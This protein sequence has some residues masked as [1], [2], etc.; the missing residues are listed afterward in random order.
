MKIL[1]ITKYRWKSR[2]KKHETISKLMKTGGIQA[3]FSTIHLDVGK[4]TITDGRIDPQWYETN[5]TKHAQ[6]YDHV[7]FQF[8]ESD[9]KRWGLDSGLRGVNIKDLD[10]IGESWVCCDEHSVVK[11]KDGTERD[12]YTKTVPHE[13]AHELK[14]KGL[15]KLEIHDFDFKDK[16]NN[17]EG[18]YCA[19]KNKTLIDT[20]MAKLATLKKSLIDLRGIDYS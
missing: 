7:I 11:F 20:L 9:G 1:V 18:F 3:I 14:N 6:D 12:K 8:S 16:I 4:P 10:R 15:T 13:I 19:L 2:L 5:I 17:I